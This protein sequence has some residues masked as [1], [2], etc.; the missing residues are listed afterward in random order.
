MISPH[1]E[2]FFDWRILGAFTYY[3]TQFGDFF[4]PPTPLVI[5]RHKMLNPHPHPFFDKKSLEGVAIDRVT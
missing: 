4:L 1:S 3:I 5:D 2:I